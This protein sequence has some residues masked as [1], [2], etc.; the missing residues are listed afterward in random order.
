MSTFR[1]VSAQQ[2]G[3]MGYSIG[4]ID[5]D[6]ERHTIDIDTDYEGGALVSLDGVQIQ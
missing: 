1:I 2:A 5:A 3:E 6:G 4:V